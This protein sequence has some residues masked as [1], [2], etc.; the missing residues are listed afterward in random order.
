MSDLPEDEPK[1][2]GQLVWLTYDLCERLKPI[3]AKHGESVAWHARQAV[4]AYVAR[5][6][7][8]AA[9]ETRGEVANG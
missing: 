4:E 5:F 7:R 9:K 3:R 8:K 1:K 2:V 6:E